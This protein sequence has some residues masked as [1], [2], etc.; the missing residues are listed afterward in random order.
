M[1][2]SVLASAV[3]LAVTGQV[4]AES[5]IA[6]QHVVV[7]ANRIPVPIEQSLADVTVIGSEEIARAGQSTLAELLSRQPGIEIETNGGIGATAN[8][9]LRG[10]N[11]QSVIVLIDGLRVSSATLGTTSWNM[12]QTNL[13]DRIEIVRGPASSLYGSDGVGGVIQIF[14]KKGQEGLH[15]SVSVGIGSQDTRQVTASLNGGNANTRYA[16]GVSSLNTDGISS[17]SIRN[18]V[19]SDDDGFRNLGANF[20]VSY[21]WSEGQTIGAQVYSSVGRYRYD[22]SNFPARQDLRQESFG[23]TSNN[24]LT[25]FWKSQLRLGKS[26]DVMDSLGASGTSYLKTTQYQ[27]SW[28]NTLTLP[29]GS[30]ILAY[31]R[32]E[33]QV[34]GSVDFSEDKR[35]NNGY[36]ASYFLQAGAHTFKLGARRDY[37]S[38]FDE[39]TTGNIGYGYQFN[40]QWHAFASHGT[41]FRAPTFNDLY[42]PFQDFG[43]WGTYVGNP[44]LKPETS[45]NSEISVAY[46]EGH[47]K[48]SATY[49]HNKVNNLIVC[50]QGLFNDTAANIGSATIQGLTLTYEA[51]VRD[52]HMKSS[53]DWQ[54]PMN[55]EN[56]RWLPRRA[57][58]HGAFWLGKHWGDWE[59]GGEVQMSGKRYNDAE[60]LV[61]LGGYTLVN[62]TGKYQMNDDWS[63]SVRANNIFDKKYALATTASSFNPTAPDYNTLGANI[64]LAVTYSP[65]Q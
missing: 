43:S 15:P 21:T 42:W 35:I 16:L 4:F 58:V 28:Q 46:D 61:A 25:D 41:A 22:G 48:V 14:T 55:D 37:N 20:N 29:L 3:L 57:R 27:V 50:C 45:R 60:N 47:H 7:T 64:F 34:D 56:D 23:L 2:K 9:H 26:A 62:L 39:H 38:Q 17:L 12:I 63:L 51:W 31:D 49:F 54:D 18:G 65:A 30:L 11:S 1:K 53:V 36:L 40:P 59:L 13:I 24:T 19:D 5:D 52:M 8:L 44:N 6:L 10:N 33:D 32:L